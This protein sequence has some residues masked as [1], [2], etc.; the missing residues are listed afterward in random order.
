MVLDDSHRSMPKKH[1]GR[2]FGLP[3]FGEKDGTTI[4]IIKGKDPYFWLWV[5]RRQLDTKGW[6]CLSER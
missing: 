1:F 3:P 2:A 5:Q 4:R 6:V